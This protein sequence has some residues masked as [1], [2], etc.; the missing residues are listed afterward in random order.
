MRMARQNL[1]KS[2]HGGHHDIKVMAHHVFHLVIAQSEGFTFS[3][4][5][6]SFPRKE[7]NSLAL[8]VRLS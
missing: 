2:G 8:P 1:C 6:T 7:K 5:I 3:C 4:I